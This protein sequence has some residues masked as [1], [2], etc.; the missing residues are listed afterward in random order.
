MILESTDA[1]VALLLLLTSYQFKY[2]MQYTVGF[3]VK[4]HQL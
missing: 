2:S 3:P 1:C 4:T